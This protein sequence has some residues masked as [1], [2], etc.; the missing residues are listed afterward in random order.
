MT[1]TTKIQQAWRKYKA[2]KEEQARKKVLQRVILLGKDVSK[3]EK[4]ILA[5]SDAKVD[6]KVVF[7]GHKAWAWASW[8]LLAGAEV[9]QAHEDLDE[10][11]TPGETANEEAALEEESDSE[12]PDESTDNEERPEEN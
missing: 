5:E 11:V 10:S 8:S 1:A 2:L 12:V 9:E 4:S 6:T 7:L 3:F